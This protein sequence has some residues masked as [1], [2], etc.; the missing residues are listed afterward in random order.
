[1]Y[2]LQ[3]FASSKY[4]KGGFDPKMSRREAGLVLGISPSANKVKVK[5]AHKRIMLLNHP[6]RGI[7]TS[8]DCLIM[9]LMFN[10]MSVCVCLQAVPHIWRRRSMK[11]K[12]CSNPIDP[13]LNRL[14][15]LT[16]NSIV[17]IV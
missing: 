4:Y 8:I 3:S 6:D 10:S 7:N 14:Q 9:R 15:C 13:P 2:C 1:M 5:E 11:P 12:I 17:N 16:M